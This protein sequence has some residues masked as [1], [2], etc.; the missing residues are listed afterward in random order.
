[1]LQHGQTLKTLPHGVYNVTGGVVQ[2]GN[3]G[4]GHVTKVIGIAAHGDTGLI[5]TPVTQPFNRNFSSIFFELRVAGQNNVSHSFLDYVL[6]NN[7]QLVTP[8]GNFNAN[9]LQSYRIFAGMTA[10]QFGE[11]TITDRLI[12]GLTL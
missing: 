3:L 4:G 12:N 1:M 5:Y 8:N 7:R 6:A 10:T 11:T 9:F 2:I